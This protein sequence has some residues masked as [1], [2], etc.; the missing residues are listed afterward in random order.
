MIFRS[1]PVLAKKLIIDS[2]SLSF[3]VISPYIIFAFAHIIILFYDKN[4]LFLDNHKTI[5]IKILQVF[6]WRASYRPSPLQHSSPVYTLQFFCRAYDFFFI[7][8]PFLDS[9]S[10][11]TK[12]SSGCSVAMNFRIFDDCNFKF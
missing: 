1:Q 9:F 3:F 8:S 7:F 2:F 12:L 5:P 4:V 11:N 10:V 6:H